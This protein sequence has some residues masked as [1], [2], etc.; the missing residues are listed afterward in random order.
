[1]LSDLKLFIP[2]YAR[3][4]TRSNASFETFVRAYAQEEDRIRKLW[5][6]LG[7]DQ[8]KLLVCDMF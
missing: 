5:L 8:K 2:T 6:Q 1:M 7:Q 3:L 4:A